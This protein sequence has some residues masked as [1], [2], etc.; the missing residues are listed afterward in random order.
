M[1][2]ALPTSTRHHQT[3]DL[4]QPDSPATLS[5]W[6]YVRMVSPRAQ[7]RLAV[8]D[9]LSG[10]VLNQYPGGSSVAPVRGEEPS[11][12]YAMYLAVG[13]RYRLLAFD[14]DAGHTS[15]ALVLEDLAQLRTWLTAAGIPHLVAASGPGG[16]R[17]VWTA[18]AG[19]GADAGRVAVLARA[20]AARL[21]TLD[22]ASLCNPVSGC[23][24]PPGAP[25]RSKNWRSHVVAGSWDVL[26]HPVATEADIEVLLDIVGPA[27]TVTTRRSGPAGTG[28]DTAGHPYVLGK[29]RTLPATSRTALESA[30]PADPDTSA[31]LWRILCGAARSRWQ[32][33]EVA[34]LLGS[35]PGL[36]HARTV[37]QHPGRAE[38]IARPAIEQRQWLA[39][40]WAKAVAFVAASPDGE[41]DGADNGYPARLQVV[42]EAVTHA[43]ARADACPRRWSRPGGPADR[44]ALDHACLTALAGVRAEI[45]LDIRSLALSTGIGRETA[46]TALARLAL[47]GWLHQVTAAA[48]PLAASWALPTPT[49]P[50]VAASGPESLIQNPDPQLSTMDLSIPR[51]HVVP[52]PAPSDS[53]PPLTQLLTLRA[54][55]VSRL[56]H[57][58]SLQ[59]HDVF[60]GTREGLGHHAGSL[61]ASLETAGGEMT[62]QELSQRTGR[63]AYE[64]TRLLTKLSVHR[65]AR[66][67]PA[68][69]GKGP[70]WRAGSPRHRTT[71]ARVL[72]VLGVLAE[73]ARR[74][75]VERQLWSWWLA[76][77]EWM[78]TP[79]RA[80]PDKTRHPR[81]GRTRQPGPGQLVL[82]VPTAITARHRFGP[83]PR[84]RGRG[85]ASGR[86][87]H[88]AARALLQRQSAGAFAA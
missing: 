11:L 64:L 28:T 34:K 76:E 87:D 46:R 15:P 80:R 3:R 63:S 51:S 31:V 5:Q 14:L 10:E 60:V 36:E 56:Q 50:E 23:V 32:F 9:Q 79:A 83:Y 69:G 78:Q 70:L 43:Q 77:L 48:G 16:G 17:H 27:P 61:Y 44:R 18:V 75:A 58:V 19:P 84:H 74:A 47:D 49:T 30:L 7:V 59:A 82:P 65:L 26:V 85:G 35:A 53:P 86:A 24:R 1:R 73:R 66:P 45:D 57:R 68:R 41:G 6:Q 4:S 33:G 81:A 71:A 42:L 13:H 62:L 72:G 22:I 55:W 25:H 54:A 88:A 12:P 8:V 20:L 40:Q 29:R 37:R 2:I 67:G 39:R 38:R 52:P 21:P